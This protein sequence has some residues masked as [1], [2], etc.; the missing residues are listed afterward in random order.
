MQAVDLFDVVELIVDM[1]PQ[2]LYAGMQGTVL[3]V[4]DSGTA[5][6]V[7][8]SDAQGRVLNFLAL[9]P[10]QFIVVWRAQEKRWVPLAERIAQ[11][12]ARL[13]EPVGVE[14]LDFARFLS[15]RTHQASRAQS[16]HVVLAEGQEKYGTQP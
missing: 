7:E 12:V 14:V 3:E 2:G 8:F 1:S 9:S 13:P 15:V 11:L 5:F 4:H 6:E 16:T 10:E